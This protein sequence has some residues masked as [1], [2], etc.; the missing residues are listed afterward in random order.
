[1]RRL[2]SSSPRPGRTDPGE[3]IYAVGDVHGRHDL[4]QELL[5]RIIAHWESSNGSFT[6][7]RLI[8]LG[9]VIDRGPDS[10]RCLEVLLELTAQRGILLL[11]GNH[12]DLLLRSIDGERAAQE[13]WLEH[14]GLTT[15]ASYG[16]AAPADHEDSFD[17]GDRLAAGLPTDH[18]ELLRT[19]PC[20]LR[21]GNYFFVHA[22]VRPGVALKR[23]DER[24]M[25][26][27][28]DDFTRSDQWHGALVVHGH[29]IVDTVEVHPN[30]IAV[31]TGAWRTGRLSCLILQ[32]D[33]QDH[34]ST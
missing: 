26:F 30:R 29:S 10:R 12:E 23:Q 14:G 18:I 21:S 24:D 5:K 8:F 16:I 19:A 11:R 15:L 22:G 34:I 20:H 28:R 1:M 2:F 3:R 13:I 7:A 17:F 33:W 27:I 32:D 9:D 25:F 31:D 4:L 6:T